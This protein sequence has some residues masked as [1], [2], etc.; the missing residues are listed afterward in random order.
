MLQWMGLDQQAERRP[1]KK[2]GAFKF[3]RR[4]FLVGVLLGFAACPVAQWIGLHWR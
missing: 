3:W 4:G 2:P 1:P